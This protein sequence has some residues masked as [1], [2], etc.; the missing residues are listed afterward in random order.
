MAGVGDTNAERA[1]ESDP[2]AELDRSRK[3]VLVGFM[4]AGKS[5]AA[6]LLA[7]RLVCEHADSDAELERRL[8]EPIADFFDREGEEAFRRRE[9]GVVHELLG[10]DGPRVVALGG[11]AVT[12]EATRSAL[13]AHVAIYLETDAE[14]AWRRARGAGRP[15]ARDR[16]AFAHLLERRVPLYQG[17]ARATVPSVRMDEVDRALAA[18]VALASDEVPPSVRMFWATCRDHG[19]PVYVG[20][21]ATRAAGALWFAGARCFIVADEGVAA[22]HG[23][24]VEGALQ[25]RIELGGKIAVSSGEQHKTLAEADRIVR[26][27]ARNGM[28]RDDALLALGGGVVG[29]LAGFCAAIYQRGVPIVHVPTTLVAQVDSAYGGKTGVDIPEAKNYVGVFHQ[30]A[31][32]I[33]DPEL[34]RTLPG[35]ELAAGFA[36]V[37]KTALIAGGTL[38]SS[39]LELSP[40]TELDDDNLDSLTAV[41]T[42]CLRTKLAVVAADE[43]DHGVRASLN[44]GHTFAHA[45]EAATHYDSYRHGEAVAVGLL[46]ALRLSER[47]FELDPQVR[48]QVAALLERNGLPTTFSGPAIEELLARAERDKKRAG[49]SRNLVLLREPGDVVTGCDVSDELLV[50]AIEELRS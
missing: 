40:V 17:V 50:E 28:Q 42:A 11:G 37:V 36:E 33:A 49:G 27:L 26:E 43:H 14:S 34:L 20:R 46:V 22:L 19:Y 38:W 48:G 45:L 41:I 23:P 39:A 6:R 47:E 2:A 29:D 1:R 21:G 13:A 35:A 16:E 15:L 24:L 44:L 32:V 25:D 4:G 9:Q 8:G 10:P 12:S 3:I 30:P 31:A 7:V 18:A 5:T